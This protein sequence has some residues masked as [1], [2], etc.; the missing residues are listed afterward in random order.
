[1]KKIRLIRITPACAGKSWSFAANHLEY[2]DHPR[3]RGEK[4]GFLINYCLREGSPP[5]ARGKVTPLNDISLQ[6]RI[7][8]AC[9]G[10]RS[11]I[12]SEAKEAT[13][14]PRMRGEKISTIS[15]DV[16]PKGS[17][18]HARGKVAIGTP[19]CFLFGITPACAGKSCMSVPSV[20]SRMGS[21][22]H[23]RGKGQTAAFR[24]QRFGITP[25]CAGKSRFLLRRLQA[26]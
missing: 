15:S 8:P 24:F 13:D 22:P 9:A 21:P 2:E 12:R 10:K 17:P 19:S 3:M 26:P 20:M 11:A 25:A 5:H 4:N 14:H 1:M 7:T 6:F 18:P 16:P 23:A